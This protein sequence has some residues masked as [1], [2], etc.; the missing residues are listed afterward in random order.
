MDKLKVPR[1]L[2]GTG[3]QRNDA[4]S[5]EVIP[6]AKTSVV[7]N[8]RAVGWDIDQVVLRISREGRPG[9]HIARP[10]PGVIFP[11][12]VA[13][14]PGLGN[15]IELPFEIAGSQIIGEDIAGYIFYARLVVALFRRVAHHD[16]VIHHDGRR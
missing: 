9:R 11:R 7:I 2:T 4:R 3:I 10:F 13:V 8:G 6:W 14:F 15:D 12:F 1:T 16:C 5:V